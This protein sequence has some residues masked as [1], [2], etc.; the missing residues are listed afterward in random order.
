MRVVTLVDC[1][2][3]EVVSAGTAKDTPQG[4]ARSALTPP[5]GS[6]TAVGPGGLDPAEMND[7]RAAAAGD[8]AAYARLVARHQPAVAAYMWRF[9]R[10]RG[11]WEELVHETFVEAYLSLSSYR[12]QA[13]WLHWLRK[14]ATRV[15]YRF[16]KGRARRRR[17]TAEAAWERFAATDPGSCRPQEAA[18][19]VHGLLARLPP[20]DR[21]VLTLYYLEECS[22]SQIAQLTGWTAT[23]VKVQAHRARGRLK[24]MLASEEAL[25]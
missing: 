15:G 13:P 16:W 5:A 3:D 2:G 25:S 10:D 20:R 19:V 8:G 7:I 17:E 18:E 11:Q 23:M 6:P 24:K 1:M 4:A 12:G 21:L 9:T 22:V 14:I